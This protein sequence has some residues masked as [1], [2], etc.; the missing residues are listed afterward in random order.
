MKALAAEIV[1][2]VGK[3]LHWLSIVVRE[4]TGTLHA[5]ALILLICFQATCNSQKQSLLKVKLLS[6]L[7]KNGTL[8]PGSQQERARSHRFAEFLHRTSSPNDLKGN[9]IA[10]NRW[11]APVKRWTRCGHR[12]YSREDSQTGIPLLRPWWFSCLFDVI[13]GGVESVNDTN[14]WIKCNSS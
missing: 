9:K 4:L 3:R 7:L 11:G 1:R 5:I 6:Q 14:S 13:P 12:D 10:G 2:K 8:W